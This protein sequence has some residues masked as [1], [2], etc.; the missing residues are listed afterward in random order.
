MLNHFELNSNEKEIMSWFDF[1]I[2]VYYKYYEFIKDSFY[3]FK[4]MYYSDN[5]KIRITNNN[6]I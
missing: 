2:F 6:R 5:E 3:G 4:H 1:Q